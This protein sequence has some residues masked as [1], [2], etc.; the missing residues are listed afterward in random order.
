[1]M[2][3][4]P[5]SAVLLMLTCLWGPFMAIQSARRLGQGPLPMSRRRFFLQT[6]VI[7]AL[8]F[9]VAFVASRRTEVPL[10]VAPPHAV[11]PWLIA[12]GLVASGVLLLRWRWPTRP[13]AGKYRL[14][15]LLPHEAGE[16]P[17]YLVVCLAAGIGEETAYR[18]MLFAILVYLTGSQVAAVLIA[19]V[20]FGLAHAVQ[21]P[22]GVLSIFLIALMAHGLVLY[23]H[24]LLPVMVAHAVYDAIAGWLIVR[25]YERDHPI[26]QPLVTTAS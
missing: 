10:T 25:L 11:L 23:A 2:G 17:L 13:A 6:V 20:A 3:L 5:F 12:A 19:S 8:L 9:G 24:S 22:R 16:Y 4:E 21:G 26:S 15:T 14:Y 7:Q 1:M 18:G